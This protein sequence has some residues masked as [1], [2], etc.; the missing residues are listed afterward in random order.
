MLSKINMILISTKL[1]LVSYLLLILLASACERAD[2]ETAHRAYQAGDY[3]TALRQLKI[4]A[5]GGDMKAQN[6]LGYMYLNGIGLEKNYSKELK[7]YRK[8]AEQGVAEAQHS[9]GYIYSEVLGTDPVYAIALKWYRLAA[10]QGLQQAQF[11]LAYMYENNI[12]IRRDDKKVLD[13][14][15]KAAEQGNIIAQHKLGLMYLSGDGVDIDTLKAYAWFGVA[16]ANGHEEALAP[17]D[18]I[19][20]QLSEDELEQARNSARKL[21]LK[22]GANS[23]GVTMQEDSA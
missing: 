22:I 6:N 10:E 23:K 5:D 7:W 2:F 12:G 18:A 20:L 19:S 4:L 11:N 1:K 14:Y 13:W 9:L 3:D 17:R 16:S 15:Q 8:A 21:W